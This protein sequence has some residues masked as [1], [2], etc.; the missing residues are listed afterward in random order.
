[1]L[2]LPVV[3]LVGCGDQKTMPFLGQW[4]GA[5][6]VE[7]VVN[8]P[9]SEKDRKRHTLR[10][11]VKIV[12]NKKSYQ[13]KLE[14]EQQTVDIKGKWKYNGKQLFLEPDDVKIGPDGSQEDLNPNR[15]S[16]PAEDLYVGYGKNLTF[17]INDDGRSL[18]G[19]TTTI[20]GLEGTHRFKKD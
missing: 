10:G 8:G 20:A 17:R 5:F 11:Y 1:M 19:L 6:D 14:G 16:V 12:L 2:L 4:N 13:M 9:D 7:K 15:K 18:T 3:A